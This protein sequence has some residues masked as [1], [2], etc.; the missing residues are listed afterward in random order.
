MNYFSGTMI[1]LFGISIIGTNQIEKDSFNNDE[2]VSK[3]EVL[4]KCSPNL[5]NLY[6]RE[7][8]LKQLAKIL[9]TA[10]PGFREY[11]SSGFH[12]KKERPQKFFVYDLTD[13]SN[14][15][16]SARY[17]SKP[18]GR[19]IEFK[20][21]HIYHVAGTYL[22]FSFSH[23]VVLEDGKLKVFKSINC[24]NSEDSLEDVINYLSKRLLNDKDKDEIINRVKN[25]RE[26]GKYFT[27]DDTYLRCKEIDRAKK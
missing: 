11:E 23:I 3:S 24:E 14:T 17:S 26:Y 7:R 2:P 13:T 18:S 16:A 6:N 20:N 1:L 9:N 10:A 25:Y 19:C 4:N 12:V 8:V 5:D 15:V 27:V 21:N 22:P